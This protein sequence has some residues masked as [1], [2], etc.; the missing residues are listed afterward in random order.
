M[1]RTQRK[2]KKMKR[3]KKLFAVILS[4]AMVMGM[5][6]TALA[7]DPAE[8]A[9]KTGD[10]TI[11]GVVE[12]A[13]LNAYQVISYDESGKYVVK[14]VEKTQGAEKTPIIADMK[15]PTVAEI[16]AMPSYVSQLGTPVTFNSNNYNAESKEYTG[17][18]AAGMWLILV[19]GSNEVIYEPMI[20]S[21]NV[22]TD[23]NL[24]AGGVNAN[25]TFEPG[26]VVAKSNSKPKVEKTVENKTFEKDEIITFNVTAQI[27]E[28]DSRYTKENIKYIITDTLSNNLQF[29]VNQDVKIAIFDNDSGVIDDSYQDTTGLIAK[30]EGKTMTIDASSIVLDN[31]G[32]YI[33]VKY[34]AELTEA[35][36]NGLT[37]SAT[38]TKNGLKVEYSN[39]PSS[40]DETTKQE[41]E[42]YQYTFGLDADIIGSE[43]TPG[44]TSEFVKVAENE[45]VEVTKPDGTGTEKVIKK[46]NGAEFELLK[47]DKETVFATQTT[48]EKGLAKFVGLKADTVYYLHETKAPDG[49]T[50]RGD[51]YVPV[52]VKAHF[53]ED[54]KTLLSYEIKVGGQVVGSGTDVDLENKGE[55]DPVVTGSYTWDAGEKNGKLTEGTTPGSYEFKNTPVSHIIIQ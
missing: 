43:S 2:E 1:G 16:Q 27:P 23:G 3:M 46:L 48:D 41:D 54:G 12:G 8:T 22:D 34:Q 42:T 40:K 55:D 35:A 17:R 24:V 33:K 14:E 44:Q 36:K 5:S 31:K 6:L 32:K 38:E 39:D 10:V 25:G 19:S 30:F 51:V 18:L 11:Q 4:L 20:V 9:P 7:A 49:Y 52:L 15:A 45:Y 28:Y 37:N 13:T 21:I 29:V 26:Q 47:S 50:L 53:S